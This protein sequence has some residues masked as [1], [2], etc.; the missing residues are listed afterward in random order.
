MGN[1]EIERRHESIM[2]L[3]SKHKLATYTH[4]FTELSNK[5]IFFVSLMLCI[6]S[7]T[8]SHWK[9]VNK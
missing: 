1:S 9:I 2:F 4:S 3:L 8:G 6:F 5:I 7:K